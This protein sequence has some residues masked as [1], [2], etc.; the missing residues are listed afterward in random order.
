MSGVRASSIRIEVDLVDDRVVVAALH[1]LGSAH[2]HV[3][4]QVVEAELVV[5]AVG[6]VAGVLRAALVVVQL[7][8]DDADAEAQ[9]LVDGAHPL[10]VALGQVVVDRD[11]VHA[12]ARER[13]EIDGQGGDQRLAFAGLHLG[14]L[15][16]VQ[17]HAADQ[18]HVEVALAEGALGGFA[19]GGE[20]R[21]Q[22]VVE[23]HAFGELLAELLRARAQ[24]CVREPHHLRFQRV[25]GLD[26]G[27]VGF[28]FAIVGAPEDLGGYRADG[29]HANRSLHPRA[30][31]R[32]P[33]RL[34][35]PL[36][37][38]APQLPKPLLPARNSVRVKL[39]LARRQRRDR[40]ASPRTKVR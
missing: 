33:S 10:G 34:R 32:E 36:M 26:L 19:H 40:P 23:R 21:H 1:H 20:G 31:Q 17:H 4:A 25:D 8:H 37:M 13:V 12:A 22:Q 15:A 27:P 2:L 11:D 38:P 16:L 39:G 30:M 6:D 3:V 24:L 9:E 5:G 7:V 14:D 28:D 35:A 18:L 29:Q